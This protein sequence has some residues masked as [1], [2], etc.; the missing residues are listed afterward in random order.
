MKQHPAVWEGAA[1]GLEDGEVAWG[2]GLNPSVPP[3]GGFAV[4]HR[5][6][7]CRVLNVKQLL[8][9]LPSPVVLLPTASASRWAVAG[10][11]LMP[12]VHRRIVNLS[13]SS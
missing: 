7:G 10:R 4:C 12:W 8:S 1:R 13:P 5:I 2:G 3:Q 9:P 11:A 6:G